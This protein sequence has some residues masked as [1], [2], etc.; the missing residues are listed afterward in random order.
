MKILHTA[1]WHLGRTFKGYSLLDEQKAILNQIVELCK[2]HQPDVLLIAGDIY[3]RSV[4]PAEAV[5]LFNGFIAEIILNQETAII[6]IA[7][8]HDS[9]ERLNYAREILAYREFHIFGHLTL[10]VPKVTL[11]D[12][13]GK[14]HFYCIPY[15]EPEQMKHLIANQTFQTHQ[16]VMQFLVNQII[17]S[18]PPGDRAV[19]V[20]HSFIIGGEGS[21]SERP[22]VCV[23][24]SECIDAQVFDFFNYTALGHLHR[25]QTFL[26]GRLQYAGSIFKYSFS[27]VEHIKSLTLTEIDAEGNVTSEYLPLTPENDVLRVKGKITEGRFTLSENNKIQPKTHDYLEVVLENEEIVLNAMQIVQKKFPNTLSLPPIKSYFMH[28]LAIKPE[29]VMHSSEIELFQDFYKKI[30]GKDLD[31]TK[32]NF[33]AGAIKQAKADEE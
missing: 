27:E 20:G 15:I 24:G 14:V 23:G 17:L 21:E 3:D 2:I 22:I 7:G 9:A 10:P 33:L 26:D 13:F 30:S 31:E 19:F 4:P 18:H 29:N 8:N 12:K 1:D 25:R 28:Q 6:A 32:E 5:A 11:E 16:A